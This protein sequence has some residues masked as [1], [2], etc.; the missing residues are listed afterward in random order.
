[1]LSLP[2]FK[3]KQI[4]IAFLGNG[5]KISFKNDNVI[6]SNFEGDIKHQSTCYR[7]FALFIVGHITVTS[8]LLQ[9]AK[10]FGF[11][12]TF[13]T[14]GLKPY[15]NWT[16]KTEGNVLLRQKQYSYVGTEIARHIV[17][18]KILCQTNCLQN[19]RDKTDSLSEAIKKLKIY[20]CSIS[21]DS[22]SFQDI[23]GIEGVAARLYFAHMFDNIEWRG[24]KPRIKPDIVNLLLDI[25]YTLLFSMMDGLLNLYGFDVYKGVYHKEFYQR[26]SLVSDLMEPFRPIVDYQIRKAFNLGQINL[27]DFDYINGQ[28]R[29]FGK[30]ANPYMTM[31]LES[32]LKYKDDIFIYV[33]QYYRAFM[34]GS[35]I[36]SYPIF[37]KL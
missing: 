30:K 26:K 31:L 33:Q 18:N 16:Y 25:G 22:L 5:D 11:N 14:Y 7:L 6:V 29:L 24:R 2:D 20:A 34:K 37:E 32:I 35:P 19:R 28:Y 12:I 21:C 4:I 1:M 9:R 8:G 17:K 23:L 3:N 15:G 13:L 10:K 36:S 27:D